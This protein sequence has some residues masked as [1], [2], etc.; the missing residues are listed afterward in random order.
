MLHRAEQRLGRPKAEPQL[1]DPFGDEGCEHT[2][3]LCLRVQCRFGEVRLHGR[4]SMRRNVPS[5]QTPA[6]RY[7]RMPIVVSIT[8]SF[9]IALLFRW[10]RFIQMA[11]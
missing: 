3:R 6:G 9:R 11:T 5:A 2:R 10:S 7:W 8:F 1:Q 4:S